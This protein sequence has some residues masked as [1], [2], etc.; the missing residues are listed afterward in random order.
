M[1]P[2]NN[3]LR[4]GL[5]LAIIL[6]GGIGVNAW[7]YIDEAK[8]PRS[9]LRE[10][11]KKLASWEQFGGDERFDVQTESVLRADDYL[12]RTYKSRDGK[13][14]AFY[15]GYYAT[16]RNGA[17]YHSPLNCLPGAG[18]S[19]SSPATLLVKPS[20]GRPAF[21]ANQYVIQ[22]G[23]DRQLMIYWYQGRGRAIASEYWGKVYTVWDSLKRHRS[24]GSMVRITVPVNESEAAAAETAGKFAADI[25]TVLPEFVPD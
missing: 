22:N 14:A 16:Q 20:N 21:E 17:T 18:W 25:S 13:V 7:E 19:M 2:L 9:V 5:L 11:P 10:F 24:D 15:V 3:S 4:F 6:L 1:A 8:A 23:R 12:L